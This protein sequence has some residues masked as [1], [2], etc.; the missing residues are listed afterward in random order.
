MYSEKNEVVYQI[1]RI[2]IPVDIDFPDGYSKK[3]LLKI[4][5]LTDSEEKISG[6]KLFDT[7]ISV[8]KNKDVDFIKRQIELKKLT[9]LMSYFTLSVYSN[10]LN[11][12]GDKFDAE[13]SQYGY[14]YLSF[15]KKCYDVNAGFNL[16]KARRD[17][18]L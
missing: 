8:I 12:I 10:L 7:Y 6:E 11:E 14:K 2:F 5:I 15:W 1:N 17:I 4:N 16:E 9:G 13:K 3:E 18:I